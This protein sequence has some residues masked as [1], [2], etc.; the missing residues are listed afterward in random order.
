MQSVFLPT[1][2]VLLIISGCGRDSDDTGPDPCITTCTSNRGETIMVNI[3][4]DHLEAPVPVELT[5]CLNRGYLP[6]GAPVVVVLAGGFDA[7]NSPTDRHEHSVESRSGIV[8]LYPSFPTDEGDFASERAGDYRGSG[9]RWATEAALRYAT[10]TVQDQEGCTL[11][12]RIVPPLS[13]QPPW[14]HGQSNGGNLALAVL[15]DAEL[16][17]PPISG[18]TTFESPMAPQFVTVELGST[19]EPLPLYVPGSCAW[20]PVDG[21]ICDIDYTLLGWAAESYDE[22]GHRGVAYFD[23]D[24]DGAYDPDN[25]AEMWGLRPDV[26]G[27]P[28]IL[29]SPPLNQA[30]HAAGHEPT[31]LLTTQETLD[32]WATRDASRL[33]VEATARYP[34]LPFLV[35]GTESD[36]VQSIEDHA[37]ISGLAHALQQ[38]GAG[39]V[40]VNPDRAYLE[41][42]L[43]QTFDWEDNPANQPTSPGDPSMAMLPDGVATGV[44]SRD[45]V[46]AALAELMERSWCGV[47][48]DDLDHVLLP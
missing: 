43:G 7:M 23:L 46:T 6:D 11:A 29:Y 19:L 17:L 32:F 42:T 3:P 47:W 27:E 39:W 45:Y 26:D 14:L 40:R 37:H 15:A 21:L 34:S 20:T 12:D 22:D 28:W 33:V 13:K 36:H 31:G 4:A 9:A 44:H 30:L 5:P 16:D 1:A 10:G 2:A 8:A 18:V 41:R 35:I 48:Q 24:D 38:A 25:D